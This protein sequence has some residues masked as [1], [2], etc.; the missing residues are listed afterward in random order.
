M[1]LL[2]PVIGRQVW[3]DGQKMHIGN[4]LEAGLVGKEDDRN[5]SI[6]NMKNDPAE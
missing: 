4:P 5:F 1:G 6:M 3:N 2:W